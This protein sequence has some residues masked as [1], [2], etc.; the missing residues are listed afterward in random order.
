[1]EAPPGMHA[2]PPRFSPPWTVAISSSTCR[3][4]LCAVVPNVWR[5]TARPRFAD[6]PFQL[7]V[8]SGD[9]TATG[10]VLWTRL[11]PRPLEPDGGMDGQRVVVTWEVADDERFTKIVQAG[12]R[13]G[14]AGARYSVHVNVDGL[15]AGPVVL[16]PVHGPAARRAPS[17]GCARRRPR[18]PTT[19]LRFAFAS[20]QHYEQGLFTAYAHMAREELDLVTH[21]GDYIYEYA[22]TRPRAQA[23]RPR[24]PHARRLSAPVRAV[25]VRPAAAGGARAAARGS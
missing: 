2:S 13:H 3:A 17:A 24:D 5:V 6:D 4:S 22:A 1:M 21:L 15:A 8:A 14:R 11:A 25:Q 16:L 19:P 20:C 9:P 23:R 18:T 7:G 12:P 10:G